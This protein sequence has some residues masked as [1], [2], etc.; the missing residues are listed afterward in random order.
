MS[1][2]KIAFTLALLIGSILWTVKIDID[3]SKPNP[4]T[5]VE[6]NHAVQ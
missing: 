4:P 6:A 5:I 3:G 1:T 2:F